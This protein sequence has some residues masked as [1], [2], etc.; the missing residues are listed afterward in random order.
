MSV[1]LVET[2][3]S[4]K[5][6]LDSRTAEGDYRYAGFVQ[7]EANPEQALYDAVVATA[8]AIWQGLYRQSMEATPKGGGWYDVTVPYE[9]PEGDP[10]VDPDAPGGGG[11]PPPP[12]PSP[13]QETDPIGLETAFDISGEPLRVYQSRFTLSKTGRAGVVAPDFDGAIGVGKDAVDGVDILVPKFDLTHTAVFG[14]LTWRY[15][16]T[17]RDIC[18]H[19]NLNPWRVFGADEVLFLGASGQARKDEKVSV[20]FRFGVA[21]TEVNIPIRGDGTLIVP[22]KPGWYYLWVKYGPEFDA[23][24][25]KVVEKPQ[26]AY[27]ERV[28]P[29]TS[30]APLNLG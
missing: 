21:K 5:F 25:G 29:H 2:F 22:N 3:E 24:S 10:G 17:L 20:T 13:P 18:G 9:L 27:V 30:F 23:P 26:A 6:R 7:A 19:T 12:P 28:Y 1:R 11:S 8:P 15:I 4:R 16:K 14:A